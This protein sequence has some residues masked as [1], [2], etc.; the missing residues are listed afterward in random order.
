MIKE[1]LI[2]V[3]KICREGET[4]GL[5]GGLIVRRYR[6]RTPALTGPWRNSHDA[7]VRDA[8]RAKQAQID[9]DQPSRVDWIVPGQI[10]ELSNEEEPSRAKG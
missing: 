4:R 3:R 7:A 2:L 8:V 10:E 1:K 9:C 5:G 6:Y